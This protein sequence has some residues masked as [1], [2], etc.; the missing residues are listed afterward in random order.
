MKTLAPVILHVFMSWI[1]PLCVNN[2]PLSTPPAPADPSVTQ[3]WTLTPCARQPPMGPPPFPAQAPV[4]ALQSPSHTR[5]PCSPHSASDVL[6]WLP[7]LLKLQH[8]TLDYCGIY[9]QALPGQHR[10]LV[11][12]APRDGFRVGLFHTSYVDGSH[13]I[14]SLRQRLRR[15]NHCPQVN[16]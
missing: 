9:T 7:F 6:C 16:S 13:L 4:G 1:N 3:C 15:T 12:S 14:L 8:L 5:V 2:L 11:R 10:G